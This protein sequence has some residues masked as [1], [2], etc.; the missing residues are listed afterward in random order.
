MG[1][2]CGLGFLVGGG[3]AVN[4]FGLDLDFASRWIYF[5]LRLG[6]WRWIFRVQGLYSILR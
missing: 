1:L 2:V 3:V 4:L 5:W 6:K